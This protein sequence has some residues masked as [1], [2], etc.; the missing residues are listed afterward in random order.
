M[1]PQPGRDRNRDPHLWSI[2]SP[3][4]RC[5]KALTVFSPS[6][7]PAERTYTTKHGTTATMKTT[8]IGKTVPI[9]VE[10]PA[11]EIEVVAPATAIPKAVEVAAAPPKLSPP[12][13]S[14]STRS[15]NCAK[16][17]PS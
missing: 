16:N 9:P 3:C 11:T 12:K 6:E 13:P 15:P 14:P 1:R 7:K 10:C 5:K 17:W 4:R 8:N 2:E